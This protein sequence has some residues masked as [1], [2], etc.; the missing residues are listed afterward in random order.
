[1]SK[2][3]DEARAIAVNPSTF[4]LT[5]T[6]ECGQVF[7][8]R[9][10]DAGYLGMIGD[11]PCYIEQR[12]D[13]LLVPAGLEDRVRHYF[14]LDHPLAEICA[15]FPDD[16]AMNAARDF[17]AGM[18]ILRQPAWECLASFITS[19]MKQV[20]HIS[21]IAHTLRQRFGETREWSGGTLF[22]YPTPERM[23]ALDEADL[24]ACALG[25][26][27]KNLRNA[28][29]MIAA[30]EVDLDVIATLDDDAARAE[31]CRLPGVGEKVANCALLFGFGRL[32]AFPV[33]VW[34]DR[35]VRHIYFQ[36]KRDVTPKRLREFSAGYFGPYAGY[37][38]Q[39]LFHHARLTWPR[40]KK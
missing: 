4:S 32:R 3:R 21:Q 7:H 30:G 15:T 11:A 37:A 12:G 24:R 29:R 35:I 36:K 10:H 1:M 38:Q 8:W 20:V 6:L 39:Y 34:I 26:R 9:R 22:T 5:A 19:A 14:A 40:G 16:P 2:S 33:D 18:R 17:A 27:A 23:G 31:L 13:H 28:A 25:F